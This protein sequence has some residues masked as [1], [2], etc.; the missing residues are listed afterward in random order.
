MADDTGLSGFPNS[1][2]AATGAL[3]PVRARGHAEPVQGSQRGG[4]DGRGNAA[5][6]GGPTTPI[7]R[8]APESGAHD[9]PAG[10]VEAVTNS[11]LYTLREAGVVRGARALL[12]VN[13]DGGFD[14][15]SCAWPD[16]EH[17]ATAEFCENGARAVAD[18]ATRARVTPEFFAQHSVDELLARSD[19]WLNKQGRLTHPMILR[20]GTG[21]YEPLAWEEAFAI[22]AAQLRALPDADAAVFYTSGRTSNEAA[23]LYQLFVRQL[24][25][26]NMPD[27]SNMCHESSGSGLGEAIGIG[28]GTVTLGDFERA[29]LIVVIGQNPGTNHPRMLSALGDAKRRGCRIIAINPLREAGLLR[30]RHPQRLGDMIGDGIDIAD[31]YLQVRVGGDLALLKGL[32]KAMLAAERDRPREVL[33]HA[34]IAAHTLGVDALIADLDQTRW[35]DIERGCGIDRAEIEQ[36]TAMLVESKATIATWAMGITQHKHGVANVQYIADLLLLR[37]MIGKPGAGLCPVRGHSNVQGDRT[38]GVWEHL[39]RWGD[40]LGE[41]FEF[42]PPHAPGLDTVAAI[43]A[44]H[45]DRVRVFFALGGNFLSATPDTEYVAQALRKCRLT[46]QVSTKLNRSHLVT[47]DTALILPCLGRTERDLQGG[48]EQFVTVENSMG[49]VHSSRGTLPPASPVLRSEVAIVAELARTTLGDDSRVAWGELAGD[50]D[51]VRDKIEAVIPG[52]DDFNR[53]VREPGG[54][55]LPNGPRERKFPTP[56]GKAL[57]T[58]HPIPELEPGAGR[59]VM[60]TIRSH[61]QFNTTVYDLDDRYRGVHGFR[62]VVLMSEHD[63]A[64]L[65]LHEGCNVTITSHFRGVQRSAAGWVVVRY[66]IPR[67]CV[68]TYFPEANVL[69][70][71][72]SFAD[73]SHTPTSKAVNVS[74]TASCE[75]APTT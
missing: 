68:A 14:C 11:L 48:R 65:G 74:I 30:F 63:I 50:Y 61:D 24:G 69:V 9:Q 18:E 15:P 13:Q 41:V 22:I 37:G 66:D 31:L 7:E 35:P 58:V 52:F 60:T 44:M 12:R 75:P 20:P 19:H 25:T 56:S 2:N 1:V 21:H 71:I 36:A 49:I 67:G 64:E 53:R 27:C 33:D 72:D 39:P 5:T 34:F 46:V 3:P 23:F 43:R 6:R 40:R 32:M 17:R 47:G 70:P 54:F 73:R 51:R 45:D 42:T 59:L 4:D 55:A 57:F 29:D 62:R 28:K 8:G 16:P 10:G 26:N 38:M